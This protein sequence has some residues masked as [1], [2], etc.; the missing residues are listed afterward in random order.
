ME[1]DW[2]PDFLIYLAYFAA[3]KEIPADLYRT[4]R[5]REE[6]NTRIAKASMLVSLLEFVE[7]FGANTAG[8]YRELDTVEE[9]EGQ[10]EELYV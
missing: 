3:D 10:A 1:W 4:H 7:R 5:L 8:L 2:Y 9:V 6:I